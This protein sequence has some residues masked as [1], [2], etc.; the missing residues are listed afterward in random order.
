MVALRRGAVSYDRGAPVNHALSFSRRGSDRERLDRE[1][2][3][4]E[5]EGE[6]LKREKQGEG[7]RGRAERRYQPHAT[8]SSATV[9]VPNHMSPL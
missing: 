6:K 8:I 2:E 3:T 7:M 5:R 4:R 1:R 9:A